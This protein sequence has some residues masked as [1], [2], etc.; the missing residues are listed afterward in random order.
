V[1]DVIAALHRAGIEI[2]IVS[3]FHV[4]LRPFF[5]DLGLLDSISGFAISCE[6]GAVKPDRRMFDAALSTIT[7]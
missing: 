6:V 5:A 1:V 7:A 3:D 2:A 4:D